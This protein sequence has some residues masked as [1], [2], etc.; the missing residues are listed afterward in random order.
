M[1]LSVISKK[2]S[3]HIDIGHTY[4]AADGFKTESIGACNPSLVHVKTKII[5]NFKY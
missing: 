4:L 2:K 1:V 5:K 3:V